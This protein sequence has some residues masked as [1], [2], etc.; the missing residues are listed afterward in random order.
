MNAVGL[1]FGTGL[2]FFSL[3]F[4]FNS[5]STC[6]TCNGNITD[7]LECSFDGTTTCDTCMPG[8]Y[9]N[10]PKSQHKIFLNYFFPIL[11]IAN[12][13]LLF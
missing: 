12:L 10:G 9:F 13:A 6:K 3:F 8:Y 11:V 2:N 4:N 5:S 1:L 7:C